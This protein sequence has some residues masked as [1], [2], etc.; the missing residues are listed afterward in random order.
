MSNKMKIAPD[1]KIGLEIHCQ[2][3][4]LHTK[5]FCD[6]LSN[7]RNSSPNENT[8]PICLG[9]PGTLPLVN[10]KAV[11]FASMICMAF[12]CLIPEKVSFYRKNYFYPDLP[13]NYQ[14][15]QYNSYE[16]SS[17][18]YHGTI[19]FV[20]ESKFKTDSTDKSQERSKIRI[21][22]VQL[23]ENPGKI[24]YE[25]DKSAANNYSLIDYNRAGVSLVEIVT[26][27]DF[28]SPI[29]VRTF[30]NEIVNMF[31][32]LGVTDPSLE[33]SVRC[34]V[35]VSLGGGNKVEIKNISSFKEVEKSIYYEIT[36]QKT[37]I[38]H[39]IEIKSETRHWDEKRKVTVAAR[40][41][42]EEE[43]Y[44]YFPEPD[45]PR[46]ILGPNF[47]HRVR[48]NMP[49]LPIDRLKRYIEVYKITDHTAKILINDKKISDFFEQSLK[50]Y[51]SPIEISN[52]IV[53]ELLTK[54]NEKDRE[55]LTDH[56]VRGLDTLNVS[57]SQV[58]EI[59]KLVEVKSLNRSIAREIFDK[60]IKSGT[61]PLKIIENLQI[62][63]I[64][65]EAS[66]VK[67]IQE[68]INS[69]PHLIEQSKNNPNVI[70]YVL[71]LIMKETK[72]R[73][74]PKIAMKLIKEA[75]RVN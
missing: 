43:E 24:T 3:T 6:C 5:L 22:R 41:K 53:N 40:S 64:S 39:D 29:A 49:E 61:S 33:G 16:L 69:Q 28:T 57:P 8:C 51:K 36:R 35:N 38:M 68:I 11:E 4:N 66:I 67:I 23:E 31:E 20:G 10:K 14:I 27:P 18:G 59:A 21:T 48:I 75:I 73:A 54:I 25:D 63:K 58:A 65:D 34:D 26:E 42:E 70:N 15:T 30:L 19:E 52:W 12:N 46:I 2:L 55:G 50:Y 62:E 32:Y 60:S 56:N 47:V 1:L 44:R 9:L 45:I 13:K 7:Y 37:L 71:G 17:I 74:N 72:G